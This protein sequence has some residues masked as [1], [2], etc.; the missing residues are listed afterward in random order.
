MICTL[1]DKGVT[2]VDLERNNGFI[3]AGAAIP[4]VR[5][6]DC[7]YNASRII[8]KIDEAMEKGLQFVVFP[9][10]SLTAYTCGDLFHQQKLQNEAISQLEF[11]L[12]STSKT[13]VVAMLGMPVRS[14]DCLYN[15]AIVIQSGKI[16]GIVPKTYIPGHR[17]FYEERWFSAGSSAKMSEINIAGQVVP[18]GTDLVFMDNDD[19]RICFGVELCEDLWVPVPPS[20]Y[21]TLAGATLIFN[22]SASN[23]LVEKNEYRKMLILTQSAKCISGYIYVSSGTGESTTDVVFG[24]NVLIYENGNLLKEAE[25]FSESE[26]LIYS[27][28]DILNIASDR[29]KNTCFSKAV[30][31]KTYRRIF[32][33]IGKFK[34]GRIERKVDPFPFVPASEKSRDVRCREIFS[35]Q[36]TGLAKRMKHTGSKSAVIGISGGLDSTLALLVIV[37]TFEKLNLDVSGITAVT[38]PGFGTT[39]ESYKNAVDLMKALNVNIRE[40]DIREACT[41]HFRDIGQ[42]P[43][44]HDS[45]YENVQARERTQ[46]LMDIA[47]MQRGIVV[48]TGDLSEIALGWSTYS[49]D[50]MSM[51]AVNCGIPKTLVKFLV[52][53]VADN[54]S[55]ESVGDV[56][57]R[58]L[59]SPI[60]PELLPPG[61]DGTSEQHTEEII[62]PY[63]LHDFFLYHIVRYGVNPNKVL[64]L[65]ECAF[66]NKYGHD[67]IVKWLRIFLTRFF[68]QQYKRSCMPD[69][70]KVG[71]V[72]LSPRGDWRMP[73]DAS[74]EIWLRELETEKNL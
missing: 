55:K 51:Y 73:S 57:H 44:N 9:E 70:P 65:A 5:V 63:E 7:A 60:S 26:Q 45:T 69:G 3:R 32:F 68:S 48:G 39:G 49:G 62:G 34:T 53:W 54:A 10:L 6:A 22:L 8:A 67:V 15:C 64:F 46:V 14:A 16:L 21:Q 47:N 50:H 1:T 23:D 17:E 19:E 31:R 66:E 71:S 38:M 42:I 59:T 72:G 20:S 40:I 28:I 4:A 33:N 61:E 36:T 35:I 58:I 43:E 13:S 29:I 2:E 37:K 18:F 27:D 30:E 74:A 11:I 56:L 12:K 52:E 41:A 25:R 24:G